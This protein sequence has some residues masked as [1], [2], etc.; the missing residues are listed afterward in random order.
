[1]RILF[2]ILFLPS[3]IRPAS[4][5]LRPSSLVLS[6]S[7]FVLRTFIALATALLGCAAPAHSADLFW[8]DNAGIHRNENADP[9]D[10]KLLF[11][12]FETRD[13]DIAGDRLFW[14]DE[15][16][17]AGLGPAGVIRT[18][19]IDGGESTGILMRLPS[20]S[21]V[22]IDAARRRLY[23][24][25]LGDANNPSAVY[26]AN[27]DGSDSR[28]IISAPSLSQIADIAI[29]PAR[30]KLYFTFINP[31]IDSLYAGG[32]A[33]ADMDGSNWQPIT[34]GLGNPL[35]LAIDSVGKEI[36][37]ADAG[38]SEGQGAIQAG[39]LSGQQ[40]R[41]ILGGLGLP[42]GVALDLAEQNVYWTDRAT[43]T[44][45]RTGMPGIL[46]FYQDV[47]TDLPAPTAIAI[48]EAPLPGPTWNVDADGN[49]STATNWDP[50]VPNTAG[51]R[52]I[53]GGVI[54]AP[55]TV[56]VDRPVTVGHIVF[57][58]MN[59]YA[60]AAA[61]SATDS[62][63]L[64][65]KSGD[66]I[67]KVITGSHTITTPI[68]LADDTVITVLD[69]DGKLTITQPLGNSGVSLTKAGA[70]ALEVPSIRA[71]SLSLNGG[72]VSL[73]V[74]ASPLVVRGSP[75]PAPDAAPD[76]T[77]VLGE[78]TIAGNR[79]APLGTLDVKA[80]AVVID[81]SAA[82]PNPSTNIRQLLLSGR[83]G[84]GLGK[85]WTG[86]G[87]TSSQVQADVLANPN[88][89]SIAFADNATLPLGSYSTF[90][91][92]PVDK[93]AVLFAYTRTGDANL[94]GIVNDD[95]VTIVGA[96]YAPGVA[97]PAWALGDFDYNGFVDD[98]D[99]TLLG[100]F[101]DPNAAP[102]PVSAGAVPPEAVTLATVPEPTTVTLVAAMLAAWA[103]AALLLR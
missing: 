95:D 38:L 13:I 48:P 49:W 19:S 83:G 39:D 60:I 40:R 10:P 76:A 69:P 25:D 46:P 62:I 34:G 68:T 16:P 94:D 103:I 78:L 1:M 29:D 59:G 90:R 5:L 97:K 54:T 57:D 22:A 65:V 51:E 27:L 99:V 74:R 37:W 82:G 58:N 32:I 35:G 86:T 80:S 63:T 84:S 4:L 92:E 21:G 11:Q 91:G 24:T 28:Q 17:I 6:P 50:R 56:T 64:D 36:Y 2:I 53:F 26:S 12:T 72:T 47:L 55:R 66:A 18:G 71:R 20:P 98:D 70:G 3:G 77:S 33:Q 61:D 87:I 8:N 101:Y 31:L 88:S 93:T 81:Y 100:V 75:D 30:D 41:T 89:T 15:L 43:G 85:L 23:W 14:S 7:S 9:P 79:S 52:A 42:Y 73:V 102:L 45:Q 96:N 67:I 44:I